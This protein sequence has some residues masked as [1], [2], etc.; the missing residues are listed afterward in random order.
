MFNLD[1]SL[2]KASLEAK[3][4]DVVDVPV[5][6]PTHLVDQFGMPI[7]CDNPKTQLVY[8]TDTG[9]H[10][11]TTR[12]SYKS[13]QPTEFL[14]A[15]WN[16]LLAIDGVDMENIEYQDWGSR[17]AFRVHLGKK[18]FINSAGQED[19]RDN[20]LEFRTGFGGNTK[21]SVGTYEYRQ[22]CSNGMMGWDF[23]QAF[24][25]KHTQRMNNKAILFISEI[26]ELNPVRAV[27]DVIS[28]T[29]HRKA[30]R[31]PFVLKLEENV[32]DIFTQFS[33]NPTHTPCGVYGKHYSYRH[34][35]SI[36]II[37][38]VH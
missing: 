6:A 32:S 2:A 12:N 31:D 29:H 38:R 24:T 17:I 21:T 22:I 15:V 14:D 33:V 25:A 35:A 11:G 13:L 10:L 27:S 30:S 20:Y 8:R 18:S 1:S 34:C 4:F 9:Q 26:H 3:L 23:T 19:E 7:D 16:S 36:Q 5:E 37:K 28:K